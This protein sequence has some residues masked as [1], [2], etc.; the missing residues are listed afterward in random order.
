MDVDRSWA[1][2]PNMAAPRTTAA[3]GWGG[4]IIG[5]LRTVARRPIRG[6]FF[7]WDPGGQWGTDWARSRSGGV[8]AE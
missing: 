7:A 1:N 4:M 5:I 6:R 2:L 8:R 3:E